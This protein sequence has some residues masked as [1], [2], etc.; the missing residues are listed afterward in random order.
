MKKLRLLGALFACVLIPLSSHAA[1]IKTWSYEAVLSTFNT[2]GSIDLPFSPT[3]GQ[4]VTGTISLDYDDPGELYLESFIRLYSNQPEDNITAFF[5]GIP[6]I[7]A[8]LHFA[9][10]QRFGIIQN[11]TRMV[12][13]YFLC[14]D[15]P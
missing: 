6:V 5:D 11:S 15:Q 7:N 4:K 10:M 3:I 2:S 14:H 13:T 1:Q 9:M 12:A 8:Q